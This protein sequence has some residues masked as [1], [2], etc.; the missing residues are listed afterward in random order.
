MSII[1][2][3]ENNIPK[4]YVFLDWDDT[5]FPCSWIIKSDI[6]LHGSDIPIKYFDQI[7]ELQNIII[8]FIEYLKDITNI[9][10]ITNAE[11]LWIQTSCSKFFP[12][13]LPLLS[14]IEIISARHLY[15]DKYP[16]D[17]NMWKTNVFSQ[18][19][20]YIIDKFSY[21]NVIIDVIS[22]GDS[23]FERNAIF[24][25][26]IPYKNNFRTKSFKFCENP[27]INQLKKEIQ[28]LHL[29]MNHILEHPA[30]F[31]IVLPT[32]FF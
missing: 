2:D 30:D 5:L 6:N 3:I 4:P 15:F 17:P 29:C 10:I 12:K 23:E 26:T 18:K 24:Q 20:R 13:L 27:S 25:A 22:I 28:F 7:N 11:D 9:I 19:I 31:D 21:N 14:N 16:D 1:S 8:N 32:E